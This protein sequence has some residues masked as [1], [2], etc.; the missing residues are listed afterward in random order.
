MSGEFSELVAHAKGAQARLDAL[1][2][3]KMRLI[4]E[5]NRLIVERDLARDTSG[6]RE[7]QKSVAKWSRK[8]FGDQP[9]VN[10]L[11]GAVEEI[12][13]LVHAHLKRAQGIRGGA[14]NYAANAMDAIGDTIIYLMDY[15]A[16]EGID[17]DASLAAA[18]SCVRQRDW[19]ANAET[20][21][22]DE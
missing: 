14:A 21:G 15:A 2:D 1:Y 8:N 12:G 22:G 9:S 19:R 4:S 17:V 20:G 10:P 18:W 11:L 3:E 13:E 6:L 16:R 5:K 7:I